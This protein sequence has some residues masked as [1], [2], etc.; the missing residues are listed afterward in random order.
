MKPNPKNTYYYIEKE[1]LLREI[2]QREAQLNALNASVQDTP[3]RLISDSL[4]GRRKFSS[5]SYIGFLI[6][7]IRESKLYGFW[8]RIIKYF[9]RFRLIATVLSILTYIITVISTG[10]FFISVM[11]IIIIAIPF[12]LLGAAIGLLHSF[13]NRGKIKRYLEKHDSING[14]TVIFMP[15]FPAEQ[16]SGNFAINTAIGIARNGDAVF[17]VRPLNSKYSTE[18]NAKNVFC[19]NQIDYFYFNKHLFR[20]YN[21]ITHI[22]L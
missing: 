19:I 17:I 22:H 3:E 18:K 20:K 10:A 13:M 6:S 21:Q 9:R 16:S 5:A 15:H 8:E 1:R 12:A 11:S 2:A 7:N 14:I 4:S